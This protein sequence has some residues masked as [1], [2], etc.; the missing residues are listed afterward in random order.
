VFEKTFVLKNDKKDDQ[1]Y[2]KT[3]ITPYYENSE[4]LAKNMQKELKF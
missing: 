4:K 1:V 2:F 3:S